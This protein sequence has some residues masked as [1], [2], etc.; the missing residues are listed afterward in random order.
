MDRKIS[1]VI[2]IVVTTVWACS[3]LADIV[4]KEYQPSA[5]VHLAMMAVVGAAFG[6]SFIAKK[7][8]G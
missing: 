7:N 6:H 4:F 5:F 2:A 1:N 8:G 3:F